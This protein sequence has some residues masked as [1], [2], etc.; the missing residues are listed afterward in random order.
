MSLLFSPWVSWKQIG[1]R[2]FKI[3]QYYKMTSTHSTRFLW[4]SKTYS[5]VAGIFYFSLRPLNYHLA[6]LKNTLELEVH[7]LIGLKSF[8]N[9]EKHFG[10]RSL[11]YQVSQWSN[12]KR[13]ELQRNLEDVSPI[14]VISPMFSPK[15]HVKWQWWHLIRG[16]SRKFKNHS[17]FIFRPI[18]SYFCPNIWLRSLDPVP[19]THLPVDTEPWRRFIIAGSK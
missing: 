8:F 19:L 18:S 14:I 15:P 16:A 6:I 11:D 1:E 13:H 12:R 17:R 9:F 7:G 3:Q 4:T 10:A 2:I 5:S